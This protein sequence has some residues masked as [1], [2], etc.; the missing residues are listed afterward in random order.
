MYFTYLGNKDAYCIL[1]QAVQCPFFFPHNGMYCVTLTILVHA[2][3][4]FYKEGILI[5]KRPPR[6]DTV[7]SLAH[8]LGKTHYFKR[9]KY[10]YDM[11]CLQKQTKI[12]QH[13]LKNIPY[14]SLL[15]KYIK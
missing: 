9:K 13:V 3:C 10:N 11:N 8:G 4:K 15:P 12:M 7:Y 2:I 1:K 6:A 14:I 5:F